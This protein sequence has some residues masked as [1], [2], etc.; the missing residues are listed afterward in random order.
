M[1]N[2]INLFLCRVAAEDAAQ[3]AIRREVIRQIQAQNPCA[4]ITCGP[5]L[6]DLKLTFEPIDID[7]V[8]TEFTEEPL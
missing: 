1:P 2:K 8:P 6:I 4:V 5:V 7:G 3:Q